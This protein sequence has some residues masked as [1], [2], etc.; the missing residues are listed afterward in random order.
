MK[1]FFYYLQPFF[2]IPPRIKSS[3]LTEKKFTNLVCEITVLYNNTKNTENT[4][5][6]KNN[7]KNKITKSNLYPKLICAVIYTFIDAKKKKSLF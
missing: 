3:Q 1:F 4:E 2:N 5:N 7:K 6:N